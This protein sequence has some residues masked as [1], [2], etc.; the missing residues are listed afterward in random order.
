MPLS[1]TML[2]DFGVVSIAL[3][4]GDK[5]VITKKTRSYRYAFVACT[6][7]LKHKVLQSWLSLSAHQSFS[8]QSR[9]RVFL[10]IIIN[11]ELNMSDINIF[12]L[13]EIMSCSQFLRN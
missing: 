2:R 5:E 4:R 8:L 6:R 7:V 10:W 12:L 3:L 9:A 13:A 1:R 11:V